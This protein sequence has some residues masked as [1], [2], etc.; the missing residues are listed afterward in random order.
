M[1]L[2]LEKEYSSSINN[3]KRIS[4][5]L[6]Q[7]LKENEYLR[8]IIKTI[9]N[10]NKD[11]NTTNS[12]L[13]TLKSS[14]DNK[15]LSIDNSHTFIKRIQYNEDIFSKLLIKQNLELTIK[16]E[17]KKRDNSLIKKNKLDYNRVKNKKLIEKL[18]K[19]KPLKLSYIKKN[20]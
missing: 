14:I 6:S 11:F 19:R 5:N 1:M 2:F 7:I 4:E 20:K 15:S 18:N 16:K 17:E 9:S 10:I 3:Q 8:E 13:G 12:S